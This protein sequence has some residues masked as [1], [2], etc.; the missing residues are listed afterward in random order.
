MRASILPPDYQPSSDLALAARK[1][2]CGALA[3]GTSLL[4]T[5]PFDVV[6]RKLQVA[7][8]KG[9]S[10]QYDGAIDCIKHMIKSEGFWR[11]M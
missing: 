9:V 2:G 10:P 7:G 6:R 8:L 3:G 11:G 4:F 1:L 5:H